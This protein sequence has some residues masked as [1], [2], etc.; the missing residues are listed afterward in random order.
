MRSDALLAREWK[1]AA[2]RTA[3][4][5]PGAREPWGLDPR[6]HCAERDT[7]QILYTYT[8]I[9]FPLRKIPFVRPGLPGLVFLKKEKTK[10]FLLGKTSPGSPGL[11]WE[12][13]QPRIERVSADTKS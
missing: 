10:Y 3:V 5:V 11:L 12:H 7:A 1:Q 4:V 8:S 2:S 13:F 9:R 6:R